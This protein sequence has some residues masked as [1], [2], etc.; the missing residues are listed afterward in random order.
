METGVAAIKAADG[1]V[2]E[3]RAKNDATERKR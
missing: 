1:K 3:I 2:R